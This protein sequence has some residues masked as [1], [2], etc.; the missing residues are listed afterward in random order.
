MVQ[1]TEITKT[2]RIDWDVL[3]LMDDGPV[4]RADVFRPIPDGPLPGH[5]ELRAVREGA[6]LP[7]GL[8]RTSG[9]A[10]PRAPGRGGRLH[11]TSTRTGSSSIRRS[12]CRTVTPA[13]ASTR[14][15]RAARRDTSITSRRAR[16]ETSTTASSGRHQPWSNGKV[17]LNGISYYAINQWHVASLQPPHL[18]AMCPWEGAAD[19]YRDMT[20]HGGILCTFWAN[21]Y[22]MQVKTVQYGLGERGPRNPVTRASLFAG[23]RPFP[24]KSWPQP[25]DFGDEIFA[26][27]LDD[28]YHKRA[29]A[30]W[31]KITVPFLSAG[32][33]EA[34]AAPAWQR[35]RLRPRGITAK[36]ARATRAGALDALLHRLWPALQKRFFDYFLKG[37][38]NGWD[39]SRRCG[40]RCEPGDGFVER[41]SR[42]GHSPAHSGRSSTSIPPA[43]R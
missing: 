41:A 11:A 22:D 42:S 1:R 40:S 5:P 16:P 4:L 28:D 27:P 3:I 2:M 39:G 15:A 23:R 30:V 19:W 26:H 14:A 38:D 31:S 9:N 43:R 25:L 12:G 18:A 17:G 8:P 34:R 37:T 32:T 33:G 20:H 35:R 24:R 13:C 36:V 29:L 10:W 21:W 7:G 6:R